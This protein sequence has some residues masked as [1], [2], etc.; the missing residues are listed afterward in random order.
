LSKTVLNERL[1]L[2]A[3]WFNTVAAAVLTTGIVAP[4]IAVVYGFA[5][6]S[7]SPTLVIASSLLC[8]LVGGGLHL[9]GRS[10]LGAL[11]E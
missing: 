7:A 10:V 11:Q 4:V 8:M 6:A 3:A 2:L 1:K 5:P 9:A